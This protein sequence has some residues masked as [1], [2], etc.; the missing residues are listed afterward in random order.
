MPQVGTEGNDPETYFNNID[1]VIYGLDGDDFIRWNPPGPLG[2]SAYIDGGR[3]NDTL[4]GGRGGDTIYGGE[5]NDL[6][7]GG[8]G[9]DVIYAGGG[10]DVV[11][12]DGVFVDG[13]SNAQKDDVDYGHTVPAPNPK[14]FGGAGNDVIYGLYANDLFGEEGD[15]T[16]YGGSVV[17]YLDGGTGNDIIYAG[18]DPRT[19][20]FGGDGN[21]VIY[22]QGAGVL[23]GGPGSDIYEVTSKNT[24]VFEAP[25]FDTEFGAD[26]VFAYVDFTLPSN[27]ENLVMIYGQQIYG[28]GND[29]ANII[30]GNA[31]NN[32][33]EGKGGYDTLTGGAG[34]DL[35][36]VN[37]N[38]GVDVITDFVAGAGT[39]DAVVFSTKLF[40]NFS[41]V[42]AKSRQVG[43]DVWIEDGLGN[44][45]VLSNV[46]L[47]VL[48]PDDFGFI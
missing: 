39:A 36:V 11:Y 34:S 40:S 12:V 1:P 32:V 37:P 16:I 19:K 38:F 18:P 42:M 2:V 43:S 14:V 35:F 3:G 9:T 22:G 44:T 6:I 47:G 25:A 7:R 26:K 13:V 4:I 17:S 27:V 5:G 45:V 20:A 21:D 41:Q 29:E 24:M 28:Y 10:N 33:L 31:S 15:D 8:G 46:N 48:H 30:I 23:V